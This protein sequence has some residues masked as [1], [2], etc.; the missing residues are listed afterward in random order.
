MGDRRE[1]RARRLEGEKGMVVESLGEGGGSGEDSAGLGAAEK[2][3]DSTCCFAF[4]IATGLV[5]GGSL[6][7]GDLA[8]KF[9]GRRRGGMG[10]RQFSW[11]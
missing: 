1:E 4:P 8:G 11:V 3:R 9:G 2:K 10:S 7:F 6:E 5:V